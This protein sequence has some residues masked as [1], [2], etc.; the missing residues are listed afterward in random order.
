M[1][2]IRNAL[3]FQI[4]HK[5]KR[6]PQ[7]P[8]HHR[9]WWKCARQ[10]RCLQTGEVK[11][12]CFDWAYSKWKSSITFWSKDRFFVLTSVFHVFAKILYK[13][14]SDENCSM[15]PYPFPTTRINVHSMPYQWNGVAL[16]SDN[17]FQI[18]RS[19][20]RYSH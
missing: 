7:T 1:K 15:V 4:T 18:A 11:N 6:P 12:P 19:S 3:V 8:E 5:I 2:Q 13:M 16:E 14:C 10:Q 9:L 20:S 17:S